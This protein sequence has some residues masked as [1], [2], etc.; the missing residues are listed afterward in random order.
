MSLEADFIQWRQ[1]AGGCFGL[2]SLTYN[3]DIQIAVCTCFTAAIR[4]SDIK[5]CLLLCILLSQQKL[6]FPTL[7]AACGYGRGERRF[8]SRMI[9]P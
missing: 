9:P 5:T 4:A 1:L 3:E 2:E 7:Q 6:F 8:A